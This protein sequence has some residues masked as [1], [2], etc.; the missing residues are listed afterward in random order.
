M[1]NYSVSTRNAA[2]GYRTIISA[3][4]HVLHADEPQAVGGH[5]TGPTPMELLAGAL[6]G[7]TAITL[8]MYS[9]RKNWP[10][11]DI[12]VDVALEKTAEG[13]R[14]AT[15]VITVTGALEEEQRARLVQIAHA[16]PVHKIVAPGLPIETTLR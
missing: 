1:A 5:D 11:D 9:Q 6:A 12:D 16:C 3:R 8:R 10:V 14:T 13:T 15:M 7:C 2:G 4:Q